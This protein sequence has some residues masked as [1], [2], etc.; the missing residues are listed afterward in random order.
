MKKL[1]KNIFF[2]T[3]HFFLYYV[4]IYFID[5]YNYYNKGDKHEKIS[6][7]ATQIQPHLFRLTE[8]KNNPNKNILLGDSRSD[9][10]YSVFEDEKKQ[11][12]NNLSYGGGSL[13]EVIEHFGTQLKIKS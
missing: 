6:S 13:N 7:I 8:F 12:W 5:P 4:C 11:T 1:I 10:L 3:I 9:A 2:F